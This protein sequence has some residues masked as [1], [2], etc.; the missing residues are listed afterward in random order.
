ARGGSDEGLEPSPI[1]GVAP[2]AVPSRLVLCSVVFAAFTSAAARAQQWVPLVSGVPKGT[3]AKV[4][5]HLEKST[6]QRTEV[7]VTIYGFW[8]WSVVGDDGTTYDRIEV[9][10]L[11]PS[12]TP[13]APELPVL[14]SRLA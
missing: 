3:P 12:S 6:S 13:G 14:R 9:P 11:P 2:M 4:E 10:G 5:V 8:R 1:E 7:E